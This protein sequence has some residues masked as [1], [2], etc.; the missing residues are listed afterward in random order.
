V[1]VTLA[2]RI[3]RP[4]EEL[5]AGAQD[6]AEG[7]FDRRLSIRSS[8][9]IH[10]LAETFNHMTERLKENVE[11]L[12]E[13][14]RKLAG[15]NE[16]LKELDRMKSDLLANVSHELRTPLTAIKG[17][18]DYVLDRK[19]GPITDKQEKGFVVVRR[20]LERLS[21]TI[22]ALLDFSRLEMGRVSVSLQPFELGPLADSILAGL[23][24]ELE[25][26][27]LVARAELAP[28]L[29]QVIGDRDK[30]SQ[31][32]ENLVVN[33]LKFTPSGGRITISA[34]REPGATRPVAQIVVADTGIGIPADQIAKI[35]KR[36]HQV[37]GSTTRRFGG[38]GLGLA[39][40]KS[41]LEAHGTAIRVESE[42]GKGTRFRFVLPL[43]E[44]AEARAAEPGERPRPE[45]GRRASARA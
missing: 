25:R 27:G 9:E 8:D 22:N 36:F 32:L 6:I 45:A 2:T 20:N 5:T 17:Y 12:E 42:E 39:I 44:R 31:V 7:H 43:L 13:S 35:F 40:V 34:C 16:E 10:I 37:D 41:I 38:V 28:D 14:N 3:T 4:V 11:Q 29:P 23:R 19:L 33:A 18:T 30:I 21:R 26:N 24:A 1:G 15:V